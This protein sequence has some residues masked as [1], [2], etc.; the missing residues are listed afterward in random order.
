M[1]ELEML[2]TDFAAQKPISRFPSITWP[3]SGSVRPF[4]AAGC[5]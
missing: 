1:I 2:Q 3:P 4:A 5:N